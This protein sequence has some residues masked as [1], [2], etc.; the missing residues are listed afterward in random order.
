[1][2]MVKKRLVLTVLSLALVDAFTRGIGPTLSVYL[3]T[4]KWDFG[5]L[6]FI[7]TIFMIYWSWLY[8]PGVGLYLV[9]TACLPIRKQWYVLVGLLY[10]I[11]GYLLYY[12]FY[13]YPE[14][15]RR[16]FRLVTRIVQYP[17][18]GAV[19]GYICYQIRLTQRSD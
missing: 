1:M 7:A 10:G 17:L 8:L 13:S 3:S 2:L 5:L 11:T 14:V 18:F 19:L 9:F 15:E 12:H 16:Y 6:G 4:G